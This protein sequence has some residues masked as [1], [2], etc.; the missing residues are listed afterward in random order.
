MIRWLLFVLALPL[1]SHAQAFPERIDRY[2]NDFADVLQADQ[3]DGLHAKLEI[4]ER[5]AGV[6]VVIAT[7]RRRADFGD[8]LTVEAWTTGLFNAWGIGS[9]AR[10]DGILILVAVDDR[11]MRLELGS[12]YGTAFQTAAERVV[13]DAIVPSFREG[14]YAQG[15]A[16][17]VTAVRKRI[18]DPYAAGSPPPA[19]DSVPESSILAP[20]VIGGVALAGILGLN[21]RKRLGNILVRFRSCPTCGQRRLQRTS[22]VKVTPTVYNSGLET[23]L[24]LCSA[25]GHRS[26]RDVT[27]SKTAI[28]RRRRNGGGSSGGGRSSGGGA[29]GRW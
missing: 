17:G 24:T 1:T 7:V 13:D 11:E 29:T 22:A 26:E 8:P 28:R 19:G 4:L 2:I 12:G 25:C 14:A 18:V 10:N 16:A 6:E 20:L 27:L 21:S 15:L 23:Q 5:E 3:E 9:A